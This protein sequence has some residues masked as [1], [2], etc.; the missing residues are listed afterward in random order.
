[1][2]NILFVCTGNTCRSPM[3]EYLLREM[4]KKAGLGENFTIA[5]AGIAAGVGE[6]ISKNAGA[7]LRERAIDP[8]R[9]IAR[10]LNPT[11]VTKADRIYVMT[12]AHQQTILAAMPQMA[13]KIKIM[14]ISDP[15]GGD[16]KV[17]RQC[18]QE[19]ETY[20]KAEDFIPDSNIK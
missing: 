17:Y 13:E 4:A 1:M 18:L 20:L 19:I 9:H 5:S 11:M 10:P 15:Y 12:E 6:P 2:K 16:I 14:R 8:S 3:A 7:V